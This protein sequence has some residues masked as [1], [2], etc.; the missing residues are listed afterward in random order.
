MLLLT[1]IA[2]VV[3]YALSNQIP[4]ELKFKAWA[5]IWATPL[6][7]LYIISEVYS[8]LKC[9]RDVSVDTEKDILFLGDDVTLSQSDIGFG[10]V[11]R[12]LGNYSLYIE[13]TSGEKYSLKPYY[14]A[15][16]KSE[17]LVTTFKPFGKIRVVTS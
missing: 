13:A 12:A 16:N 6:I 7:W 2:G 4:E 11:K 10:L 15:E 14:V 5:V 17:G 9:P 1:S 3:F 8:V